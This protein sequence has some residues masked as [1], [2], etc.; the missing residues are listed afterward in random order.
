MRMVLATA[1]TLA[2]VAPLPL[3]AQS[4]ADLCR[5]LGR[6]FAVGQWVQYEMTA[7]QI[8]DGRAELRFAIVGT[9]PAAGGEH[10]WFELMMNS[11]QG[12]Y[13]SQFLVPGFPYELGDVQA[14]VMK[15]GDQ[16]A[17]KMP[18]EMLG[19]MRQMGNQNQAMEITKK[20]DDAEE[21]GW[22]SVTVPAGTLRALHLKVKDGSGELWVTDELPFGMVKWVGTE[23]EQMALKDHGKDAE[24]SI[25]ETPQEMPGMPMRPP[26]R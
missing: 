5:S 3:A 1:V 19:M 12:T 9:E 14:V 13:I 16:P 2:C 8:P 21:V 6:D 18:K 23:G 24:S 17:M 10:Y 4:V 26:G 20:C 25:T 15:M 22:E 7:S 11:S